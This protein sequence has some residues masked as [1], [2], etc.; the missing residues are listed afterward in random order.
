MTRLRT[1]KQTTIVRR[2]E[3]QR[4][5]FTISAERVSELS[6]SKP[7][8][9]TQSPTH[10]GHPYAEG[11]RKAKALEVI[12][13]SRE[14]LTTEQIMEQAEIP[15]ISKTFQALMALEQNGHISFNQATMKYSIKD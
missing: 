12:R 2:R 8:P 11:T 9:V 5:Q 14:P 3:W 7:R 1:S 10:M 15:T 6:G 4:N 13:V